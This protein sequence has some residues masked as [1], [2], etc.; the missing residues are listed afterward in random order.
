MPQIGIYINI[1]NRFNVDPL[2]NL[3]AVFFGRKEYDFVLKLKCSSLSI[4]LSRLGRRDKLLTYGYSPDYCYAT[5]E[6]WHI[7][8]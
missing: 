3:P 8:P 5:Q 1:S 7:D 2:P 6:L 4:Y